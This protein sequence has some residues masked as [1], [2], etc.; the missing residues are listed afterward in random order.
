MF[1]YDEAALERGIAV[2]PEQMETLIADEIPAS[3]EAA[4]NSLLDL[5]FNLVYTGLVS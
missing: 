3:N 5:K 4:A 1:L 2:T